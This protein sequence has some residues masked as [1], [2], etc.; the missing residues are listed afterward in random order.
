MTTI[1]EEFYKSL[2]PLP[3]LMSITSLNLRIEGTGGNTV[4]YSG[5]IACTVKVPFLPE[6][7]TDILAL[8]VP[9]TQYNLKVPVV[10]GTNIKGKSND[11]DHSN[12]PK[13]WKM[14]LFLS[15]KAALE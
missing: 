4:P 9:T 8:V 13:E 10:A 12:V 11:C 2:N 15:I 5:C 7:E 14:H 3:E 1:S 6:R